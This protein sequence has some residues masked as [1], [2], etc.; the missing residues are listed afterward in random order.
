MARGGWG[1]WYEPR[2]SPHRVPVARRSWST[3]PRRQKTAGGTMRHRRPGGPVRG[4]PSRRMKRRVRLIL[5]SDDVLVHLLAVRLGQL[6]LPQL[7][8]QLGDLPGEA[9][10]HL[11]VP[12][13]HGRAQVGS[14]VEG[15]V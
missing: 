10:R 2:F 3:R 12:V 11:V 14:D 4:R 9:E 6:L 8:S 5:G 7:E 13:V 15:L 1:W